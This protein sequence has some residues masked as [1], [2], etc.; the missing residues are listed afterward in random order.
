MDE[1]TNCRFVV[2]GTSIPR[3]AAW[4]SISANMTQGTNHTQEKPRQLRIVC[5]NLN[6][7]LGGNK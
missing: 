3:K 1:I 2:R 4:L 5:P 7:F 6:D